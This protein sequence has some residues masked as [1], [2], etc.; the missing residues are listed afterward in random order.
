MKLLQN[1]KGIKF[2]NIMMGFLILSI[3]ITFGTLM[4][5]DLNTNYA[6]AGVNLST[7]RYGDVYNT[8]SDIF[9]LQRD[10]NEKAFQTEDGMSEIE[11]A[12]ATIRGS[13]S[14]IR[15]VVGTYDLFD[16]ITTAIAKEIGVP[17]ILVRAAYIAF[18]LTI[19]F[20]LV[21][22]VFRFIPR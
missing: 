21:Y 5:V 7:E 16:A 19:V 6:E 1:K 4:M 20:S 17:T 22:L 12:D 10:A 18:V 13:Y 3:F 14:V 8:T 2:E 9:G 11:S 15:V